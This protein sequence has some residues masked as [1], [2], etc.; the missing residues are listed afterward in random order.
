MIM[1]HPKWVVAYGFR[2][3]DWGVDGGQ[4]L[5]DGTLKWG[6]VQGA[7][8]LKIGGTAA[9]RFGNTRPNMTDLRRLT[10]FPPL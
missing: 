3:H 4:K 8:S 7:V 6:V 9:L 2:R 10:R 1:P 5:T